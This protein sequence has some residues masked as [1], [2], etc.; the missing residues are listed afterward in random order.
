MGCTDSTHAPAGFRESEWFMFYY[1]GFSAELHFEE[2]FT[3]PRTFKLKI[4]FVKGYHIAEI[5]ELNTILHENGI[6]VEKYY[7]ILREALDAFRHN[8]SK[9]YVF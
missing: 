2:Q 9:Y 8:S 4:A 3:A 1:K 7:Q 5:S 6:L